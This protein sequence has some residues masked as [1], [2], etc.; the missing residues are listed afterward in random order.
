MADP[1]G[2]ILIRSCADG[3]ALLRLAGAGRGHYGFLFT[4]DG[5]YLCAFFDASPRHQISVYGLKSQH[6]LFS[7]TNRWGPRLSDAAPDGKRLIV[8]LDTTPCPVL[9]YA[10]PSGQATEL[11]TLPAM[12]VSLRVSPEGARLALVSQPPNVVEVRDIEGWQL[13]TRRSLPGTVRGLDWH[14]DGRLLAA[15]CGDRKIHLWD[16]TTGQQSRAIPGH[17]RDVTGVHFTHGGNLLASVSWDNTFRLWNVWDGAQ[18]LRRDCF[19]ESSGFSTD[20][21]RIGLA[22]SHSYELGEMAGGREWRGLHPEENPSEAWQ[23][24][25]S[26]DGRMLVSGHK[27][28]LRLWN[29]ASGREFNLP[30]REFG[31]CWGVAFDP[32]GTH[33]I[34]GTSTGLRSWAT[35]WEQAQTEQRLTLG[36]EEKFGPG[37][38]TGSLFLNEAG[39]FLATACGGVVRIFEWPTRREVQTLKLDSGVFGCALSLSGRLCLGWPYAGNLPRR[40]WDVTTGA[41]LTNLPAASIYG[42]AFTPDDRLLITGSSDDYVAWDTQSWKPVW[43]LPRPSSVSVQARVAL[44]RDGAVGAL[45]LSAQVIR[46]FDPATGREL[47]SLEAPEAQTIDWLAFSPDGGELA[48]TTQA[49]TVHLW[50]L[51]L[52]R[53]ELSLMK[54]DWAA[55]ALPPVAPA[56]ARLIIVSGSGPTNAVPSPAP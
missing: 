52:I 54:L 17:D 39:N 10:L 27:D 55:P 16:T 50:N 5:Q 46:L 2:N 48:A 9:A 8:A 41:V 28:C 4:P 47:A 35:T 26:P 25:W 14:P 31:E 37:C 13:L 36:D 34:A 22:T 45:T 11:A 15:A 53:Q 1:E 33:L 43:K 32:A 49:G 12:P 51:R 23:C 29:V 42:A 18:I 3:H 7:V 38:S 6:L 19:G 20:D 40:V 44:T 21:H 56:P 24:A 30:L